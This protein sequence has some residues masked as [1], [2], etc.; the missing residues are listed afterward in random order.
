M[1]QTSVAFFWKEPSPPIECLLVVRIMAGEGNVGGIL[2]GNCESCVGSDQW[3]GVSASR[4]AARG[5][6]D[7]RRR[8]VSPRRFG[9]SA[10]RLRLSISAGFLAGSASAT[11]AQ[12]AGARRCRRQRSPAIAGFTAIVL[13]VIDAWC[14]ATAPT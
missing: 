8:G 5:Q 1:T 3:T 2:L 4:P 12:V 7:H 13:V 6:D 9:E 10:T 14:A 11:A